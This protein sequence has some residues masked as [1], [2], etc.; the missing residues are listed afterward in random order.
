MLLCAPQSTLTTPNTPDACLNGLHQLLLR[1]T[2]SYSTTCMYSSVASCVR[3]LLSPGFDLGSTLRTFLSRLFLKR[4]PRE[5]SAITCRYIQATDASSTS[6]SELKCCV[7]C[8]ATTH[9]VVP[10][11]Q[12][13]NFWPVR[14]YGGHILY[15]E[16]LLQ[17]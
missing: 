9:L 16:W 8:W 4:S 3:V 15:H 17:P 6:L 11:N 13:N 12:G 7:M 2:W 10:R 5:S 1:V 14:Q